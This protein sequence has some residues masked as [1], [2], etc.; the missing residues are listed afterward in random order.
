VPE[1]WGVVCCVCVGGGGW[2][3]CAVGVGYLCIFGSVPNNFPGY[4]AAMLERV[5]HVSVVVR[6]EKA[7]GRAWRCV[8]LCVCVVCV[9]VW[10]G[11][12]LPRSVPPLRN[13]VARASY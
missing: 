9:C 7:N 5:T 8:V 13:S 11:G 3:G 12:Y 4:Q 6:S 1:L 10:G 2:C